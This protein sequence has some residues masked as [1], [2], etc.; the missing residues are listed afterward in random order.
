MADNGKLYPAFDEAYAKENT[1]LCSK[2]DI[3]LPNL[4]EASFMT[5]LPYKTEYDRAYIMEM[6][7]ALAALGP[8][9]A[10]LTGVSFTPGK[11]GV[12]GLDSR[13]G[14]TFEYYTDHVPTSYHGTGDIFA[15][16]VVGAITRGLP[17]AD[18]FRIACDYTK[19]TV[20]YTYGI[21]GHEDRYG[22]DFEHTLPMLVDKVRNL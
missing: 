15:S 13:T 21:F 9:Y 18:A 1:K 19:E 11:V 8:K 22:V 5:G 3:I 7:R 17:V 20:A 12:M 2:A 16:T 6:L 10:V 14:E 4:T